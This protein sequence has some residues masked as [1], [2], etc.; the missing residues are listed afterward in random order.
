L[1]SEALRVFVGVDR[2]AVV[3]VSQGFGGGRRTQLLRALHVEV[4]DETAA[5]VVAALGNVFEEAGD[6]ARHAS[7]VLSNAL[8]RYL[9]VPWSRRI[10]SAD[11]RHAL[12]RHAFTTVHGA[13]AAAWTFVV[14]PAGDDRQTL[15]AAIDTALLDG[16]RGAAARGPA[17][18]RSVQPLLMAVFN[19][20]RDDVGREPVSFL[21][22]EPQRWCWASV[23]EGVWRR[24]QSGRMPEADEGGMAEIVARQIGLDAAGES[25]PLAMP[26]VWVYAESGSA[27]AARLSSNEWRLRD[28][29]L[30]PR[31]GMGGIEPGAEAALLAA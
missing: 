5:A 29:V 15:A 22:L 30:E 1:S 11:E 6:T 4:G 8:V 13:A 7:I 2:I 27:A 16:L 24:V 28:L 26:Q 20:W 21:V 9:V 23:A 10:T 17:K 19:H 3:R 18:L 25:A 14:S 31:Q 12:A